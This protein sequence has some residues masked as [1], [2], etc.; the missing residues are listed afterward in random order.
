M[1]AATALVEVAADP[2]ATVK[3][4][5]RM[6]AAGFA[7]I[8]RD[9]KLVASPADRMNEEQRAFIRANKA[10]L[11]GLLSDAE[12]VFRALM[13]AGTAGLGWREGTPA[14]WSDDRLLAAGE[15][16]YSDG[17][18][19]NR[20]DRRYLATSAPAIEIGPEYRPPG[21]TPEIASCAAVAPSAN[22]VPI[23]REAFEERAAIMEFDG[24]LSRDEAEQK[25][26]ALALRAAELQ[27]AGWEPWNAKARAESEA[28]PGWK[29]RP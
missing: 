11:V 20:H 12:T 29:D 9:G 19:V 26:L 3:A 13:E 25:A 1:N 23:D 27:A 16:L 24:G 15:V 2:F 14:D 4:M 8:V 6:R 18:M 21:E 22:V 10:A 5:N 28:L 7:L 17:R